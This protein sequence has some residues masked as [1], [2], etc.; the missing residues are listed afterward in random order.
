MIAIP[1]SFFDPLPEDMLARFEGS[2]PL[3]EKLPEFSA[4]IEQLLRQ[5]GE[6][7]LAQQI[8]E[9]WIGNRCRC[10]TVLCGAFQV[11]HLPSAVLSL[12]PNRGPR[13]VR[14]AAKD[15]VVSVDVVDGEIRRIDAA[16]RDDVCK[17]LEWMFPV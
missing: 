17:V 10:G 9:L 15:G 3:R 12:S 11:E 14:I 4:E 8:A 7:E 5:A 16:N 2:A 1:P 13:S 6:P